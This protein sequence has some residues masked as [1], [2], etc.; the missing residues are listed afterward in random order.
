MRI[1][2]WEMPRFVPPAETKQAAAPIVVAVEA[3]NFSRK[4]DRTG[5]AWQIV[6]GLGRTGGGSVT[7][8]PFA[9]PSVSLGQVRGVAPVLEY[10]LSFPASGDF[11][12]TAYLIPTHPISGDK[13]RFAVALDDSEPQ[14]VELAFKD[15]SAEW[16]QGVLNNTRVAETVLT[17]QTAGAH[18]L[19]VFGLEPGVV[20]DKLVLSLGEP[21]R[22]YLGPVEAQVP[23]K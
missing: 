22:S 9:A 23:V 1:A 12:L 5:S 6:P 4:T 17:V 19:R 2:R 7:L 16:A 8:M 3:E 11:T 13:L 21:P 15:G 18:T 14:I 20:I 10:D